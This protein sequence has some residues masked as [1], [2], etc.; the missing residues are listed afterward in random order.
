MFTFISK[1]GIISHSPRHL[2]ATSLL[3]P[4]P[5]DPDFVQ[6]EDSHVPEGRLGPSPA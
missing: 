3:S 4:L 5:V 1:N 2:T 6:I